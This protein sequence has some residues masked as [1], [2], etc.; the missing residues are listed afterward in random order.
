MADTLIVG[1][2]LRQ[3]RLTK[4]HGVIATS[5]GQPEHCGRDRDAMQLNRERNDS[6]RAVE[7]HAHRS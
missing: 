4:A 6:E 2:K 7:K 1:A 3:V 5:I